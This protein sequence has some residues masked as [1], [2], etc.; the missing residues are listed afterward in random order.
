MGPR[1]L[2]S[3][4]GEDLNNAKQW[5]A[6]KGRKARKGYDENADVSLPF[7]SWCVYFTRPRLNVCHVTWWSEAR[8]LT[9][10]G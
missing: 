5:R 8:V 1:A 4:R 6:S 10:R 2:E 7:N 3:K 9:K